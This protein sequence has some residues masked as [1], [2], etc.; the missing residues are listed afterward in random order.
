MWHSILICIEEL[1]YAHNRLARETFR[2]GQRG[3][4]DPRDSNR[5]CE[6]PTHSGNEPRA[7][8]VCLS[9]ACMSV[10]T[11]FCVIVSRNAEATACCCAS[12]RIT[13]PAEKKPSVENGRKSVASPRKE[14]NI[15]F[16]QQQQKNQTLNQHPRPPHLSLIP[17][18]QV[19]TFRDV[20]AALQA[21][22]KRLGGHPP[23]NGRSDG[24]C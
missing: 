17:P 9:R 19:A 7:R 4:P 18:M 1:Y 23:R 15:A 20:A 2:I 8:W 22:R 10:S 16:W 21:G 24:G 11:C 5:C 13:S 6:P 12:T 14:S 3:A